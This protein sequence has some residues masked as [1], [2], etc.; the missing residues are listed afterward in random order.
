MYESIKN[1][2]EN[3]NYELADIL[4]KINTVWLKSYITEE[5]MEEL[6]ELAREKANT[7]NSIDILNKLKE[8]DL[9]M[10]DFDKRIIKLENAGVEEP[11]EPEGE[12]TYPA[13]VPGKWYYNGN[14]CSENGKNYI[15]IAPSGQV[16]VW[17]PSEYPAYW[18]EVVENTEE[19]V[20]SEVQE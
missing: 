17:S 18:Q 4:K 13:Y 8:I 7:D 20:E 9:K 12:I 19:T 14:T 3:G 10:Q 15:C 5:E 1:L 11:E 2:I 16:C 6:E